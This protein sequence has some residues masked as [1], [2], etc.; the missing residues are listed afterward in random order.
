MVTL[1]NQD[2]Y[3]SVGDLRALF[4]D[5]GCRWQEPASVESHT[6]EMFARA[7]AERTKDYVHARTL[8]EMLGIDEYADIDAF[9]F[10]RP[11]IVHDLNTHVPGSLRERFGLVV[12]GGTVEHIFDTRT[13]FANVVDMTRVSGRVIHCNAASNMIDHGFWS[14]SPSLYFDLY[15]AN[16]FEDLSATIFEWDPRDSW[17]PC[18]AFAYEYGMMIN[19]LCDPERVHM[20]WFTARKAR[21]VPFTLPTQG[22][23]RTDREVPFSGG[24]WAPPGTPHLKRRRL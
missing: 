15:G 3:A 17:R 20:V 6:S 19:G 11:S 10:D 16:G 4:R 23:Y 8:F 1:G 2:V 18:N 7:Y 9:A 13:C 21:T 14:I 22:L 12:D 5:V 24:A